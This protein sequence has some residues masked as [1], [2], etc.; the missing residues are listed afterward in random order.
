MDEGAF[1]LELAILFV[2]INGPRRHGSLRMLHSL[3]QVSVSSAPHCAGCL[4]SC[5]RHKCWRMTSSGAATSAAFWSGCVWM[6]GWLMSQEE[7][8]ELAEPLPML[9]GKLG[10]KWLWWIWSWPRQKQWRVSSAS[11]V[12][13]ERDG[14]CMWLFFKPGTALYAI[15]SH[16]A[17]LRNWLEQGI[18]IKLLLP[19]QC[20]TRYHTSSYSSI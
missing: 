11:K 13:P 1:W 6:A 14:H 5:F 19:C 15:P 2:L 20:C 18:F 9:W 3:S 10:L 17:L 12:S 7:G 8:R 16:P 4:C